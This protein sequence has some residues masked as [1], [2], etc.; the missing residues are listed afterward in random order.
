MKNLTLTGSTLLLLLFLVG[1][2]SSINITRDCKINAV[3]TQNNEYSVCLVCG[4]SF[5]PE[6]LFL[7]TKNA[8]QSKK[9][10]H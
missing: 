7:R 10:Q 6:Q 2:S 9:N 8:N 4:F 1:C 5:L 3:V